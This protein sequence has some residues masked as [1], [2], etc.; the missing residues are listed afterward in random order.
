MIDNEGNISFSGVG[1]VFRFNPDSVQTMPE[2][3]KL[4]IT[5]QGVLCLKNNVLNIPYDQGFLNLNLELLQLSDNNLFQVFTVI[6]GDTTFMS[7]LGNQQFEIDYGMSELQFIV[8]NT[9]NNETS[10]LTI[11]VDRAYPFWMNWW[12]LVFMGVVVISLLLGMYS[13]I[14]FFQTRRLLQM[15]KAENKV[16][17]ERLRIS[18]ELHDN[19]GARLT[20]IISSLDME[21]YRAKSNSKPIETI[22]AFARETMSQLRETIWAVGDKTIFFSEFVLRVEQY[23]EQ[24]NELTRVNLSTQIQVDIDFELNPIQTINYFRIVQ[25]AINNA[26]KYAH[27]KSIQVF[28]KHNNGSVLIQIIDDGDG[29]DQQSTRMG[30]GVKGMQVRATEAQAVFR[31]ESEQGKGT[32]IHLSI[33]LK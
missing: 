27:A 28:I 31:F 30:T 16:N 19:I 33:P 29:F 17:Q 6:D 21:M 22:N 18:K 4:A 8:A 15:Q 25:E 32:I 26:L 2:L 11:Q 23:V 24:S 3:P 13:A 20:H 7:E 5:R 9:E 14:K 12:F 10:I 1:G